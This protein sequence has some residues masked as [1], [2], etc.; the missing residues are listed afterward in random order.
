MSITQQKASS[1]RERSVV[2]FDGECNFCRSQIHLLKYLDW[3]NRRLTYL[4]LHDPLIEHEFPMLDRNQLLQEMHIVDQ[5]NRIFAGSN[6]VKYLF[7][8]LPILWLFAPIVH[9][10]GT[11]PI[12]RF[13]YRVIA[14]NRYRLWGKRCD[15]ESC[16]I[17]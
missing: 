13:L 9:F 16:K 7:R 14:K 4:S 2:I 1:S 10:P 15:N 17:N 3:G 12:W 5:S 6:A 11:S 8:K